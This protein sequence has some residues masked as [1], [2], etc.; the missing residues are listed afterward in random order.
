MAQAL[1]ASW[2]ACLDDRIR[3]LQTNLLKTFSARSGKNQLGKVRRGAL[4]HSGSRKL[5]CSSL[6]LYQLTFSPNTK[7]GRKRAAKKHSPSM[8]P[9]VTRFGNR[10]SVA[11]LYRHTLTPRNPGKD[12]FAASV[13]HIFARRQPLFSGTG[14]HIHIWLRTPARACSRHLPI[15]IEHVTSVLDRL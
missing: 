1:D 8:A 6:Q 15:A 7:G 9:N 14:V 11:L 3:G 5:A 13:T 4:F 2:L 10:L 12:I